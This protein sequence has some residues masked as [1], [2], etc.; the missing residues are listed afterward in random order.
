MAASGP[1]QIAFM[2]MPFRKRPIPDPPPGAP[3]EV[4]FDAL[5]D[6]ALRPALEQ[7][8]FLAVR[9]DAET[10]TVILKDMLERLKF[11]D[12]VLADTTLPNGNVYYEIGIRHAAQQVGCIQIGAGWSRRLFDIEQVR[13]VPYPLVDGSIPE[14]EAA[15][16]SELVRNAVQK[17]RYSKTPFFE[18]VTT[19]AASSVFREQLQAMSDFQAD[20]R[21]VRLESDPNKR[22]SRTSELLEQYRASSAQLPEVAFE[23]L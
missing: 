23:L 17:F 11:S 7:A 9:A 20:V 8:G 2:V 5:W 13:T 15:A 6:R 21:K 19:E 22:R 12:L 14:A 16:I 3:G 10:S 18:L 4:D 1:R